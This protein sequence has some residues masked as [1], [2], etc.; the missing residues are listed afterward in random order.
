[1]FIL[2]FILGTL[3]LFIAAAVV[4]RIFRNPDTVPDTG[5]DVHEGLLDSLD[6]QKQDGH[7]ELV[8]GTKSQFKWV[9]GNRTPPPSQNAK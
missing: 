5:D 3:L 2:R 6:Q 7:T 1:M 4:A 8:K 9:E